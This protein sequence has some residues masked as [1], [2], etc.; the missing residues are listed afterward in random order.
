MRFSPFNLTKMKNR[1]F[2]FLPAFLLCQ[3]LTAQEINIGI[4]LNPTLAIPII[5]AHSKNTEGIGVAPATINYNA[6]L[7]IKRKWENFGLE[8]GVN[9][10]QKSIKFT[11]STFAG[12]VSS[13]DYNIA[14]ATSLEFPLLLSLPMHK[15]DKNNVYT[16][17]AVG[18]FSYELF[19]ADGQASGGS[20]GSDFSTKTSI[21]QRFQ[22]D[23]WVNAIAGFQIRTIVRRFGLIEYGLNYHLPLKRN[24][25]YIVNTNIINANSNYDYTGNYA[26]RMSYLDVKLCYYFLNYNNTGSRIRYKNS[27]YF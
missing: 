23:A 16:L 13:V 25:G 1:I 9:F 12:K 26:P 10:M 27:E 8:T 5:D 6:G 24:D 2:L 14:Y 17:E 21:A 15:H 11:Q 4:H 19:Y 20:A 7:N 22:K 3:N 18:G